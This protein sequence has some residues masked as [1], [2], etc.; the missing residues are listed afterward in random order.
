MAEHRPARRCDSSR[1]Q[2]LGIRARRVV[3]K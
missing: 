3:L 2:L 1:G